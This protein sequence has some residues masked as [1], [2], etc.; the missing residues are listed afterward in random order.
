M[1]DLGLS[2]GV[3]RKVS[4]GDYGHT[5]VTYFITGVGADTT[6]EE[7]DELI[8]EQGDIAFSKLVQRLRKKIK[9]QT[10][11]AVQ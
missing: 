7:M 3:S 9:A 10:Q 8:T 2:I 1:P 6:P 4:D 11:E 5:E